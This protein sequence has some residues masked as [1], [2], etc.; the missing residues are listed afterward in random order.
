MDLGS[1]TVTLTTTG[2][3]VALPVNVDLDVQTIK[4]GF[5]YKF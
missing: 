2:G 3:L 5:N 4:A 1:K